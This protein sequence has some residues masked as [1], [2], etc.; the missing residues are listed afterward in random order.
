MKYLIGGFFLLLSFYL[1]FV[2]ISL[3]GLDGTAESLL[4]G[5]AL[6]LAWYAVREEY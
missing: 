4:S 2:G 6:Y 3:E 1:L 5:V